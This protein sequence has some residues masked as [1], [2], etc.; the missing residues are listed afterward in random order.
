VANNYSQI[1][2]IV[3]KLRESTL[4]GSAAWEEGV[5]PNV[6]QTRFGDFLITIAGDGFGNIN[7]ISSFPRLEIK[8]LDGRNVAK[9]GGTNTIIDPI[10]AE[11][12]GELR[13]LYS[14]LADR[15]KDLDELINIIP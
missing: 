4:K 2:Q 9:L 10:P 15:S 1:A 12:M 11:I 14:L 5:V 3:K 13:Q 8:R 7:T 6:Y